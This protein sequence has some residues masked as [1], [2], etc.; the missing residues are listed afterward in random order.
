MKKQINVAISEDS[1][2]KFGN[3]FCNLYYNFE[4]RM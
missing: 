4:A 2:G 3:N 1:F